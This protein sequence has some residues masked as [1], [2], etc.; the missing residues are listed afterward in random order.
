[1]PTAST[2]TTSVTR[3]LFAL[4]LL[5][6]LNK[7]A[8]PQNIDGIVA[9]MGAEI[10]PPGAG[11]A[12]PSGASFN[13]LNTTRGGYGGESAF[14]TIRGSNGAVSHVWNYPSVDTG[15]K[16]TADTIRQP[17]FAPISRALDRCDP[18]AL[19]SAVGMSGWGTNPQTMAGVYAA[20]KQGKTLA[21]TPVPAVAGSTTAGTPSA[22]DASPTTA[23]G[24]VA[25]SGLGSVNPAGWI[26]YLYCRFQAGNYAL[27]ALEMV[28]GILLTLVG[29]YLLGSSFLKDTQLGNLTSKV[30]G[31][32]AAAA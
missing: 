2:A 9:W 13:P 25:P 3:S 22:V 30:G 18:N 28:L 8:C 1:M 10:G 26:G 15:I 7:P 23:S 6:E 14:N 5:N 21:N 19:I 24:C 4:L 29:L 16:A 20:M 31:R 12:A 32:L 27:R 11:G 17:N